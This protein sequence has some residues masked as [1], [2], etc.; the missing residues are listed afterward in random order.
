MAPACKVIDECRCFQ[1]KGNSGQFCAV[2]RGDRV[3]QC[4]EE[5][6]FGGCVEDGSR[7][8]F[9][10][11]GVPDML[12]KKSLIAAKEKDAFKHILVIVIVACLVMII[13]L[14]V[15]R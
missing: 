7:P 14:K 13:S 9:R 1:L 2:R 5:C 12:N 4:P 11:I 8:P 6:C 10:Y 3:I 15:R